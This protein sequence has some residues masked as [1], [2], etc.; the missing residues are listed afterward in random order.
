MPYYRIN[1]SLVEYIHDS[2]RTNRDFRW[3]RCW[4]V[5]GDEARRPTWKSGQHT[6]A[7]ATAKYPQLRLKLSS[8]RHVRAEA[9]HTIKVYDGN[10]DSRLQM[11]KRLDLVVVLMILVQPK[12]QNV[13]TLP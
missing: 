10:K 9:Q 6:R 1:S 5:A 11:T 2:G 7:P 8:S 13:V 12:T 3:R 4:L